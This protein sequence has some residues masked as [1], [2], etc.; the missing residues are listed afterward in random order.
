MQRLPFLIKF[1]CERPDLSDRRLGALV[2]RSPQTV[3]RYRDLVKAKRLTWPAIKHLDAAGLDKL[4]NLPRGGAAKRPINFD[5][6]EAALRLPGARL[7]DVWR[8]YAARNPVNA[9]GYE[10]FRRRYRA[11]RPWK[12]PADHEIPPCFPL[13]K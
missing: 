1:I 3:R 11:A 9:I 6:V 8:R 10:H 5:A 7:R 2:R 4:L 12:P 13:R